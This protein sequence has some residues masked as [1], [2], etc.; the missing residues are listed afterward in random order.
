MDALTKTTSLSAADVRAGL[1]RLELLGLV[2]REGVGT[3]RRTAL[4]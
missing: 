3:Y 1:G 4:R 2:A